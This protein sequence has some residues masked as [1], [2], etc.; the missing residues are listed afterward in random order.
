[1]NFFRPGDPE[2][3]PD[4]DVLAI[5][6]RLGTEK[7]YLAR[8]QHGWIWVDRRA[9][10]GGITPLTWKYATEQDAHGRF[11]LRELTADERAEWVGQ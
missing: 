3:G 1:M 11:Q 8:F 10:L 9:E 5:V 4:V 6:A 7:R 2:P